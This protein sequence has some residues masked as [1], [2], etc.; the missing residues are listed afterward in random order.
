MKVAFLIFFQSTIWE[1]FPYILLA[2]IGV[3]GSTTSIFLPETAGV[4]LP[5]TIEEAETFGVN[6]SFFYVPIF[7]DKLAKKKD[8]EISED[9]STIF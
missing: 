5:A 9:V 2:I 4:D 7:H 3:L 8:E 6:Q 1:P